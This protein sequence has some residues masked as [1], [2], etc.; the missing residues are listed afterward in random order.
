ETGPG[1]EGPFESRSG[2]TT[3]THAFLNTSITQI[4]L[5]PTNNNN[6]WVGNTF[7]VGGIGGDAPPTNGADGAFEG[8][9]FSSNAQSSTPTWIRVA[10]LPGGG[11]GAT[12]HI[13]VEPGNCHNIVGRVRECATGSTY[14]W[15]QLSS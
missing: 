12:T 2:S 15:S 3:T 9:Y 10:S 14:I 5:D 8:L 7:G 13:V 6:M 4:V 1:L 11:G